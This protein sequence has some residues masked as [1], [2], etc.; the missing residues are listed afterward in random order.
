[1]LHVHVYIY[2]V[3]L[4]LGSPFRTPVLKF[5]LKFPQNT[6]D[7]FLVKLVDPALSRMF[8]WFLEQKE[9][10]PLRD[11]LANSTQKLVSTTFTIQV[12]G[13]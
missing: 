4:Q 10:G 1:M 6:V 9:A 11:S 5:S 7:F 13:S 8:R 3:S 2:L 12:S